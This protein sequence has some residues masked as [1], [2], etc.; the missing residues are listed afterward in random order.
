MS[1]V[2]KIPP[3][4]ESIPDAT[5]ATWHKQPGEA[6]SI[7]D[8]LADLETDKVM[9]ELPAPSSGVLEEILVPEGSTVTPGQVIARLRDDV[10]EGTIKPTP[11]QSE[12]STETPALAASGR[13]LADAPAGPAARQIMAQHHLKA[14]QI[15]GSG[16]KGRI[17]KEDVLAYLDSLPPTESMPITASAPAL[18]TSEKTDESLPLADGVR[19]ERRVPM[20]RL[21]ARIAERLLAAQHNTAML[22]TFNEVDMKQVMDLRKRYREAFEKT[23][24][25]RLGLMSFFVTATVAALRRFPTVNASIDGNDV[26]YHGYFDIGIA[27]STPRGLIV[28]IL[29]NADQLTAADIER[30]ISSFGARARDNTLSLDDITGGTFTITNGGVFGSLL[31]TPILNPPQSAILGMHK[32]E[33]RAVVID[34]QIVARPMMYV[35]LTYDHRIIDGQDAVQFLAAIKA[36]LEDP[37]RLLLRL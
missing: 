2:V 21:R 26:V 6:V 19:T 25:T 8:N 16:H 34:G 37:A 36:V 29:R 28:P 20:T 35:A 33:E 17:L 4:P 14:E 23:H 18:Q 5:L 24:H 11:T 32:I 13:A 31:S 10:T 15:S 22:T 7:D 27:V 12:Q 30:Q 1:I 9:L 3:L